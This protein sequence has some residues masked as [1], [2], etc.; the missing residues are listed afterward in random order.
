MN[1][2]SQ[3]EADAMAVYTPFSN[4]GVRPGV[5][6]I[7]RQTIASMTLA[8]AD[9]IICRCEDVRVGDLER[10]WTSRQAKLYTRAGMG[11]CQGRICG[12]ALECV[13][14]WRSDTVRPPI[15]PARLATLLTETLAHEPTQGAP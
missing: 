8:T 11:A 6:P 9:T 4:G 10:H 1:R 12:G 3:L 7:Q 13:M 2:R 5:V 15:Q 14:G